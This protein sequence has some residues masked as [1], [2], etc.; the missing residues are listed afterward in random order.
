MLGRYEKCPRALVFIL[1]QNLIGMLG[2]HK[3][4]STYTGV[5]FVSKPYRYARKSF[6]HDAFR[7]KFFVSKPYRYARKE[8]EA[9]NDFYDGI[10]FKTL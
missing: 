6:I 3:K 1:F 8:T 2:R 7:K 4:M 10:C 9:F 5:Y